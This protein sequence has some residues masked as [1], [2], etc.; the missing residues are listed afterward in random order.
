[1]AVWTNTIANKGKE[2]YFRISQYVNCLMN[3]HL[4]SSSALLA[5]Y[6]SLSLADV[7]PVR[8]CIFHGVWVLNLDCSHF[9][10]CNA[11]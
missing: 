3:F 5:K 10:F 2:R 4:L 1:M 8:T 7:Y 11:K 9:M 6:G